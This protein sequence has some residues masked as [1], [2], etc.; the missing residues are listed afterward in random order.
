[1]R[2]SEVGPTYI[3][4]N[5]LSNAIAPA[6]ASVLRHRG[7]LGMDDDPDQ[8]ASTLERLQPGIDALGGFV[9]RDVLELG[10]GRTA[11]LLKRM[12]AA[13]ARSGTGI[14]PHL[15]VT[16]GEPARFLRY[17]GRHIPLP[18]GSIDLV[19]SKSVLEHVR[20]RD[21]EPLVANT[22]RVLRPGGG[23]V[24]IIDL[25]DHMFIG[26]EEIVTGDWLDALRYSEP[27]YR[28]MFSNK[29]VAINRLREP[30]W[31]AL[32]QRQHFEIVHWEAT[33]FPL[34]AGFDRDRLRPEFRRLSSE[35][36]SIGYLTATIRR[37]TEQLA[38]SSRSRDTKSA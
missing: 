31:L 24:H 27:L 30:D 21:V 16:E 6:L 8:I 26:G 9:D 37:P 1:M 4:K 17:D 32:F 38:R 18:S 2:S 20:P 36:L 23:A 13:G 15:A 7:S 28:A 19:V 22:F 34:P 3:A 11:G 25:R 29:Q 5:M 35:T 10:S 14:D 12:I 33:R